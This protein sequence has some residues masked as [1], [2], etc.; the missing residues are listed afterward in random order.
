MEQRSI[1]RR[2]FLRLSGVSMAGVLLAACA[3]VTP[4]PAPPPKEEAKPAAPAGKEFV[5]WGLQYDP[6]VE[7]YQMLAEAF[8]KKTGY[9]AI[10]EPQAWP[11]EAKV[12]AAMAAGTVPDVTCIMGKQLVPLLVQKALIPV[13]DV[14]QAAG[15]D[16]KVFFTPGAIGAFFYEGSHWGVPVEDNC[17]GMAVGA[18][19]DWIEEAGEDAR[20]LWPA[21]QGKDGFD[22]FEQ[23]WNLAEKLQK[24]DEAGNV[25]VWGMN[26]QGWDNRTW[27]GIMRDLGRMWWDPDA[28]KFYLDSEEAIEAIKLYITVPV[29][30]R[31]IET[32]LDMSH[33]DA[34]LAGK[35]AIGVGNN[36]MAGEAEKIG[37][38]VESVLR[39]PTTP[40]KTPLFVGEGGWGFEVPVQAKN[41]DIGIQFLQFMCT[42]EAQYI[43]AGIYG[44]TMTA[45]VEV[46]KSDIYQGDTPVKRSVRRNLS[47]LANT[48]YYG[49]G[50]GIPSE[51]ERITTQTLERVRTGE[52]QPE[53]AAKQMQEQMEEHY[54]QWLEGKVEIGGS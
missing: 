51:M 24:T 26:S 4:A 31:K 25:T 42:Y 30:E 34:L 11:V 27:M 54:K 32:Q 14:F 21:A 16:P 47:S 52:L 49:W 10:I 29:F 5:L 39:P 23:L 38:P 44:G 37:V 28:K 19:T 15:I 36:A 13:E 9:K 8:E 1:S 17:V 2:S 22:S 40:G 50:F 53:E 46:A 41:K 35:V 20:A 12:I 33:M 48:V 18:R 6:H 7:R 3:P 43:F 45:C